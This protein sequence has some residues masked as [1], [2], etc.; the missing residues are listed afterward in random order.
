M[1]AT[2]HFYEETKNV[3]QL[4]SCSHQPAHPPVVVPYSHQY[5]RAFSCYPEVNLPTSYLKP[6]DRMPIQPIPMEFWLAIFPTRDTPSPVVQAHVR[7]HNASGVH[8]NHILMY[9]CKGRVYRDAFYRHAVVWDPCRVIDRLDT[10]HFSFPTRPMIPA[11]GEEVHWDSEEEGGSAR[12]SADSIGKFVW[13]RVRNLKKSNGLVFSFAL[14]RTSSAY[15]HTP[16]IHRHP[17]PIQEIPWTRACCLL[18]VS[19]RQT[20]TT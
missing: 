9:D 8:R 1:L 6:N 10:Q 20:R 15:R 12:S 17:R 18:A 13:E 11:G 19:T 7:A 14:T 5:M 3:N 2:T 16:I 4:Q